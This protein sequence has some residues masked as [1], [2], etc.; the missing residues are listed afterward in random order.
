MLAW[1][2]AGIGLFAAIMV[3]VIWIPSLSRVQPVPEL[4]RLQVLDSENLPQKQANSRLVLVGDVHGQASDLKRLLEKVDF[5]RRV[6]HLVLLGDFITK[7]DDSIGV[8][9]LAMK[10]GASCV[11]GNHEDEI[12][13]MYA[14]YHRLPPPRVENSS[15]TIDYDDVADATGPYNELSD[16][17]K[18]VRQ[19]SPRHMRYI[20]SCPLMLKLGDEPL[21]EDLHCIAVHAGLQWN[22]NLAAQDPDWVMTM[23]SLLPPDFTEP[24]EEDEGEEWFK[25]WKRQQKKLNKEDRLRVYYGHAARYGL[26]L[27]KYSRGLDTGCVKGGRLSAAVIYQDKDGEFLEDIVS[28]GC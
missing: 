14:K 8:V 3:F 9:D 11:R 7:G 15:R 16:D 22:Y 17:A 1:V 4:D 20:S 27:K 21:V 26:Q 5:D 25:Q 6:D 10:Y 24:S 19:L 12:V 13:N 23:R 28:V 2:G 18:L